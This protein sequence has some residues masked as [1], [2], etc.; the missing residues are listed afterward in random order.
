[1]YADVHC[2]LNHPLL[3]QRL[4]EVLRNARDAGVGLIVTAG[5]NPASNDEVLAMARQHPGIVTCSL[6]MYP[7]DALGLDVE[8]DAVGMTRQLQPMDVDAELVRIEGLADSCVAIGE[9]GMDFK[10]TKDAPSIAK[11]KEIFTKILDLAERV[12]KPVVVH[13]RSAEQECIELLETAT[14]PGIVMHCFGGRK[15]LIRRAADNGWSFSVPPVIARLQ[16]FQTLVGLVP[17]GQL[18]TETDAPW[19]G[20]VAGQTNEPMNV[21]VSVDE[22]AKALRADPQHVKDM[23]WKNA[24]AMFGGA[25]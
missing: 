3:K 23:I 10:F 9:V 1:M 8:S 2:H 12:K 5:V 17:L 7:L 15:S 16:H 22:I 20:P 11:Q 18:L 25:S 14:L 21:R 19:L 4:D 6:G 13:S 24:R